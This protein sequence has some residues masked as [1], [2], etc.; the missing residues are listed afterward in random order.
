VIALSE[1]VHVEITDT[2]PKKRTQKLDG[3][4]HC[5]N[6]VFGDNAQHKPLPVKA[7]GQP[8]ASTTTAMLKVNGHGRPHSIWQP[9]DDTAC[10]RCSVFAATSLITRLHRCKDHRAV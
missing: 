1:S 10:H 9:H 3:I 6:N 8:L 4:A 2:D 5:I 7:L